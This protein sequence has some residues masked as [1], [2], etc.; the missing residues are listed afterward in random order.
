MK[1]YRI[2]F[3]M[4]AL[5]GTAA[6][7]DHFEAINTNPDKP[8]TVTPDLIVTQV[9]KSAFRFFN[10]VPDEFRQGDNLMNK[11]I[12]VLNSTANPGQYFYSYW[13]Y[14]NFDGYVNLTD[15]RLMSRY[16]AGSVGAGS[17]QGFEKFMK[18]YYGFRATLSMGDVPYSEAGKAQEGITQPKYDT[19]E[20]V[21]SGILADLQEAESLFAKGEPFNG[22]ILFGGD[23]AKWRRLCNMLQLKVLQTMSKKI[24]AAGKSRFSQIVGAGNLMAGND[25]N[26]KLVYTENT[27]ATHPFWNG[28]TQ[29]ANTGVTELLV[30]TLKKYADRRLFYFA[31]PAKSQI[32]AGKTAQDFDAYVGAP[33]EMASEQLAVNNEQYHLYSLLNLRYPVFRDGDP[34]LIFTYSEQCFIIAE[35]IEEGWLQGSARDWYEKGVSAQLAYYRDLPHTKDY[36]HGMTIDDEYIAN[37][38]SGEAAYKTDGSK[39]DRLHQIWDQ[40]WLIEFFSGRPDYY[41]QFLRTGWPAYPLDPSTCMNTDDTSTW[42]KRWMYPTSEQTT[43]PEH[44]QSAIDTQYGGFDSVNQLPWYLK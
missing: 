23:A 2:L 44:Y 15:L 9:Q 42:P 24:T 1:R 21:F 27:N 38:F 3:L 33:S 25:D 18:A 43:N 28:T 12:L 13:P 20:E 22:D 39:T 14:G 4:A 19:Q 10:P 32:D 11:H 6:S 34:M 29:Q 37:Y 5:L 35:A 17:Y 31:E 16:S 30:N 41:Y 26:F 36:V 40:R 7:C 8:T